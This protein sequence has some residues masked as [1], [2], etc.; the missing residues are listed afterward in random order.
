MNLQQ[1]AQAVADLFNVTNLVEVK[2]IIV[3]RLSDDPS[4]YPT[5]CIFPQAWDNNY[6]SLGGNTDQ[7]VTIRLILY[8]N[9]LNNEL[10]G[11]ITLYTIADKIKKILDSKPTITSCY[12]ADKSN[13]TFAFASSPSALGMAI[14]DIKLK[15]IID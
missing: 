4:I 13:G 7:V 9:I 6:K 11:Q 10:S 14:I 2:K 12:W 8:H 1:L 3:G 5:L 15:A